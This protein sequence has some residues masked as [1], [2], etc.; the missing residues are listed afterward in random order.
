MSRIEST[1]RQNCV[2]CGRITLHE[3]TTYIDDPVKHETV[4]HCTECG[5]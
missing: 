1:H 4:A 3:V 5:E 2:H